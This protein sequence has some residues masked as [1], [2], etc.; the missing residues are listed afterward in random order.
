[1]LLYFLCSFLEHL[2][3]TAILL[4]G[5]VLAN[6]F[7]TDTCASTKETHFEER[8]FMSIKNSKLK[9][10]FPMIRDREEILSDISGFPELASTFDMWSKEQQNL[11]LDICSGARGIKMLYDSFFKE[12]FNPEHNPA[13]LSS[14]LSVLLAKKVT[15]KNVLP[16]DSERIA[17]EFALVITDIVVELED[18][19]IANVEVQK[20]GYLFP[21][22]RASCYTADLL[23]RQYKRVRDER[24]EKFSYKDIAPV[25]TI[26][27]ME[28]S[29]QIF[30]E[31]PEDY[32]HNIT[33]TSDTGIKLN[34]LQNIIF[35]PV[36]IFINKLHN[37]GIK[38]DLDAWLTFLGCD[39]P[40]Y[41]LALIQKYPEFKT[42]YS[43]IY[44]MCRNIEGVMNMF[45]KDLQLMDRNTA[46]YMIDELQEQLDSANEQ[47]NSANEQLNSANLMIQEKD[48]ALSEKEA[49][50]SE[51]DAIIA[52]LQAELDSQKTQN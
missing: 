27:F 43:H 37:E 40:E 21:G 33:A 26:I 1:M 35:I 23:L 44:D 17:D 9:D 38:S 12:I 7:S 3:S 50:L 47:L 8:I 39:E 29:P 14:L 34:L 20:I 4:S 30:R 48:A 46:K 2:Y 51:K 22:E 36:D 45:S 11:F 6:I 42:M 24:R 15:V 13:R 10:H 52:R 25:Y 49:A 5:R 41:I 16:N 19:T 28:K 32:I 18:G 31:F